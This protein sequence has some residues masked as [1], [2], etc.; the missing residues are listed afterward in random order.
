MGGGD[1]KLFCAAG[2]IAGA[3]LGLELQLA[4]YLVVSLL[5]LA[6]LAR[7]GQILAVLRRSLRLLAGALSSVRVGAGTAVQD[8]ELTQMRMG[9]AILLASLWVTGSALLGGPG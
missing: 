9:P 8:A 5:A 3:R 2:A 6:M 7:G 4:S 1:L